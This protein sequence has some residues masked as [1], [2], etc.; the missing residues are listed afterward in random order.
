MGR[1][2]FGQSQLTNRTGR[3]MRI[4]AKRQENGAVYVGR[5]DDLHGDGL[6][7]MAK[8]IFKKG[9]KALKSAKKFAKSDLVKKG[10]KYG[11]KYGKQAIDLGSKAAEFYG[12][13]TGQAIKQALIPSETPGFP[14]EKHAI[15]DRGGGRGYVGA[16]YMGPGTNVKKR[17]QRG[18]IGIT[19][20]DMLAMK[21]DVA[22]RKAQGAKSKADQLRMIRKADEDMVAGL[23]KIVALGADNPMNIK[24]AQLIIAKL[25]AEKAGL[26]SKGSFGGELEKISKEEMNLLNKAETGLTQMGYGKKSHPASNLKKQLARKHK[27]GKG[28]NLAGQGHKMGKGL[29][30]AGQG[31]CGKGLKLAGQGQC[32]GNIRGHFDPVGYAQEIMMKG[33]IS[34]ATEYA[35]REGK[36]GKNWKAAFARYMKGD[37]WAGMPD[38]VRPVVAFAKKPSVKKAPKYPKLGEM[39]FGRGKQSGGFVF[40]L[41]ALIAGISSAASA[42]VAAAPTI[43]TIAGAVGATAGAA[44]AVKELVSGEGL[45]TVIAK[46]I[47]EEIKDTKVTTADLPKNIIKVADKKLKAIKN[48]KVPVKEK[49]EMVIKQVAKPLIPLVKKKYVEKLAK[50]LKGNGLK[51]AGQGHKMGKGLN[52]A[53]QGEILTDK[54]ILDGMKKETKL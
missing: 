10:I 6:F 1:P 33:K 44:V 2:S 46:K 16:N 3:I 24:Q 18:D 5:H 53:G 9:S 11:K 35:N 22:Y 49:K 15:L 7:S 39:K 28:L 34:S 8:S 36:K 17:L 19:P 50:N 45:K 37:Q 31:H 32:G 27:K 48:L 25:G 4:G 51:L 52:L 20:V 14:G 41:A 47:K 13:E 26:I 21:H 30:L 12:S 54:K 38:D 23:K 43:S 42:V 29:K 40:T